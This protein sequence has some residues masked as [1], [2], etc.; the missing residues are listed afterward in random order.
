MEF[1]PLRCKRIC[2]R[3]DNFTE[4][5]LMTAAEALALHV[6][7]SANHGLVMW[8]VT[9]SDP[10][11][12]GRAVAYAMKGDQSGGRRLPGELVAKTIEQLR[13]MLPAGLTRHDPSTYDPLGTVEAWD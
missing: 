13:A 1:L 9:M 10:A 5:R 3:G 6:R 4:S 7:A 2:V 8:F 11:H 12:P